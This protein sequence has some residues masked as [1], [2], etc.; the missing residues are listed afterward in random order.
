MGL[1]DAKIGRVSDAGATNTPSGAPLK[2]SAKPP[3]RTQSLV[4]SG[5]LGSGKTTLVRHLLEEGRRA[6]L[7]V[8][9]VSNEFGELGIDKALLAQGDDGFVELEGGCVCCKLSDD[10]LRTLQELWERSHPDWVIVETS[11]LALPYDTLINFWRAPVSDWSCDEV[12]AVV[13]NAEQVRDGRDLEGTFEDQL[14]SADFIVLNKTDL[15]E[16]SEMAQVR[17]AVRAVEPDAPIVH[18]EYGKIAAELLF[19]PTPASAPKR[20]QASA[21]RGHG[22]RREGDH[23]HDHDGFVTEVLDVTSCTS[24]AEV[25]ECVRAAAGLRAKG[26]VSLAGRVHVVQAVA[27]RIEI[28]PVEFDP[29]PESLGRVVI[30]RRG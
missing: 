6:G 5:F 2:T 19:P 20:R 18:A 15:I 4:V 29:D 10:L 7:R 8:A 3:S 26:F 30:I 23:R 17:A 25:E 12:S 21:S 11:G 9:V 16:E 24:V 22:D 13:V 14:A 28:E 27:A 1:A